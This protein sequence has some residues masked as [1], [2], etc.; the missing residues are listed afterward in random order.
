MP[1]GHSDPKGYKEYAVAVICAID[2]EI[3][4]VRYMLDQEYPHLP[5]K[6]GDSNKYI[7]GELSG[8]DVVLAWLP[9]QQG[10]SAAAIVATNMARTFPSIK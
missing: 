6:Q 8:H 7:L 3:S 9:G 10:K 4:A 2:F 1:D 5:T